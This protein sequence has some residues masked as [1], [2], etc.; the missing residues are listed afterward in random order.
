VGADGWRSAH[1]DLFVLCRLGAVNVAD[2][3]G[4][5]GRRLRAAETRVLM[6]SGP[7]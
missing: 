5:H 4:D 6:I 7:A 2:Q 1:D 3:R